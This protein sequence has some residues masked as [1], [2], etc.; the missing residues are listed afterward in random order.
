MSVLSKLNGVNMLRATVLS[1]ALL[2]A[3]LVRK[4]R[5]VKVKA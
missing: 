5:G 1:V 2:V 4:G 3:P